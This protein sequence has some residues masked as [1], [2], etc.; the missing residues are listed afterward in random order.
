MAYLVSRFHGI[1]R[2]NRKMPGVLPIRPPYGDRDCIVI[3]RYEGQG[4]NLTIR[5]QEGMVF[6]PDSTLA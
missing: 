3:E 2:N 6:I 1:Q 5:I 4:N